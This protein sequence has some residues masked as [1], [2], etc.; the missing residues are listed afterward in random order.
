MTVKCVTSRSFE[1]CLHGANTFFVLNSSDDATTDSRVFTHLAEGAFAFSAHVVLISFDT[2]L[3]VRGGVK[4]KKAELV[5]VSRVTG[6]RF[7]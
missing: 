1:H 4:R 2:Y 5:I 6:K 7:F 3:Q